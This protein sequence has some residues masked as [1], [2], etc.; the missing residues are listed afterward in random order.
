[1]KIDQ[2]NLLDFF[3]F[4]PLKSAIVSEISEATAASPVPDKDKI[5][6]HIGNPAQDDQLTNLYFKLVSNTDLNPQLLFDSDSPNLTDYGWEN[7]QKERLSLLYQAIKE[8]VAYTPR[9]G[10]SRKN[11]PLLIVFPL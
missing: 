7:S 5:N 4:K 1:M 2:T 10:F 8:A 11:I 6:F 9:G 3:E